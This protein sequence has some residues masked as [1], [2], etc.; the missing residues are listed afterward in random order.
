MN[1]RILLIKT[2]K[3]FLVRLIRTRAR[4]G[5]PSTVPRFALKEIAMNQ[6]HK[7]LCIYF[8][9]LVLFFIIGVSQGISIGQECR[10][11][12]VHHSDG[13]K[14]TSSNQFSTEPMIS[15]FKGEDSGFGVEALDYKLVRYLRTESERK[16][17]RI[18][19]VDG[20]M[21]NRDGRLLCPFVRCKGIFVMTGE[22]EIY[23]RPLGLFGGL[24]EVVPFIRLFKH[25]SFLAGGKVAAAG[26]LAVQNGV[27]DY[28]DN[29]SGHYQLSAEQ[30]LTF[31]SFLLKS[32]VAPPPRIGFF[33]QRALF[34]PIVMVVETN[35]LEPMRGRY[36]G[37]HN[38]YNTIVMQIQAVFSE[39]DSAR[40]PG[41]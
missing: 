9:L 41:L 10:S 32:G 1:V 39:F 11:R 2:C 27:V 31:L 35:Q 40:A 24:I 34:D 38:L 15:A 23:F 22:G 4:C 3:Q 5:L 16:K 26:Y 6:V 30:N 19:I 37:E 25:S 7:K 29:G 13:N 18:H 28:F 33:I 36:L 20:R 12:L 17:Y 21:V 8:N 14:T